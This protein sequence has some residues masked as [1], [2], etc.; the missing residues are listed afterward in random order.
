MNFKI[1]TEETFKP[2]VV[3][4]TL[5]SK[6]EV[7]NFY[8]ILNHTAINEASVLDL[9]SLRDRIH[10]IY[11]EAYDHFDTFSDKVLDWFRTNYKL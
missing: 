3:E 5:T 2:I 7:Q 11:P 4:I 8:H 9:D 10:D 1:T 6:E